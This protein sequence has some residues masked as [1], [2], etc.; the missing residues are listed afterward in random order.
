MTFVH[1]AR[2]FHLCMLEKCH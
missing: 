1:G 2:P